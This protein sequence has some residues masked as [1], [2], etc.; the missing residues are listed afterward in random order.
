VR[1]ARLPGFLLTRAADAPGRADRQWR[2]ARPEQH[3]DHRQPRA[4][5]SDRQRSPD[6]HRPGLPHL[7]HQSSPTGL[8][9]I[10]DVR[11]QVV[12]L[13]WLPEQLIFYAQ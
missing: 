2:V 5:S 13:G 4:A 9:G 12:K 11:D 6:Q 3:P 10:V 1:Q 8:D 7:L